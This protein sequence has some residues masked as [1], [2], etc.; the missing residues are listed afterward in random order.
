MLTTVF[1]NLHEL[2]THSKS[3]QSGELSGCH[4]DVHNIKEY[5]MDVHE[6]PEENITILMDDGEHTE[7]TKK[8]MEEAYKK[9]VHESEPGDAVFCHYSG[10]GGRLR[11][12]GNDEA[13]GYDE[14]LIPVDYQTAGQIRDDDLYLNLVGAMPEG[15]QLT[16]LMDCW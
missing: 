7:P 12:D 13:D 3:G 1:H 8:N 4:N 15:V 10:H 14:T 6:F 16:C 11:D 2:Y 9:L 5:L